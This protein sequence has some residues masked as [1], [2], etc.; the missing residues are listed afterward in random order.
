MA[1]RRIILVRHGAYDEESLNP[2]GRRQARL[3]AKRL[4]AEPI[5]AIHCSTMPRAIETA[6]IIAERFPDLVVRRTHLLRECLPSVPPRLLKLMPRVPRA[7][8][9]RSRERAD[10]AFARFF[11]PARGKDRCE[12]IVCHGN[13]IRYLIT[14]AMG[15]KRDIW[16]SMGIRNCSLSELEINSK[17]ETLLISYNDAGHL[18]PAKKSG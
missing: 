3:T 10:R 2:L 8:I 1:S 4:T 14:Q 12:L 17:G 9:M 16:A 18:P 5:T 6:E 13:L 11:K 15:F 7:Q